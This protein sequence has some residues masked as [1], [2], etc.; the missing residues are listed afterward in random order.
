M[1]IHLPSSLLR[2]A[3]A[4]LRAG[5]VIAYATESCYGLGCLPGN[6]RGL[7]AILRLKGRPNR[8][9]MI[10]V[11]QGFGELA[12]LL[13]PVSA[14]EEASM[15]A[16]WPGPVTLLLP[17]ARRTLPLLRGRHDKLA[18]RVTAHAQTAALCRRLGPLVSTSANFAGQRSLKS[19]AACR[20]AFGEAVLVLPGQV[21]RRRKPSTII[22]FASGRVLR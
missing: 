5:G 20:R 17:A 16:Y 4:T 9:G 21:G 6:A 10:V 7:K 13:K 8:K 14:E 3:Q 2:A 11:G 22:D 19:A 12:P 1:Q 15:Q 18:V